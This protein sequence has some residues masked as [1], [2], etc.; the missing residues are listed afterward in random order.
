M[1]GNSYIQQ[2][3]MIQM[4]SVRFALVSTALVV[5]KPMFHGWNRT[6]LIILVHTWTEFQLLAAIVPL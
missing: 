3:T 4:I 1:P 5:P 2:L 6:Q